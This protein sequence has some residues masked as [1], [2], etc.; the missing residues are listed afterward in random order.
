MMQQQQPPPPPQHPPP[1]SG[2]GGGEFYRGPP[3]RQL[4]GASS[5]N[6]PLDYAAHPGPPQQHQ[7]Q[8][9]PPYDGNPEHS[10]GLLLHIRVS[11]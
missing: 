4:S 5:T 9:Q 6:V 8:H 3:M 11:E 7:H 1:Q 2:G 10:L